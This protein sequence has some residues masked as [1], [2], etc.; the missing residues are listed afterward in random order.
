VERGSKKRR[1]KKEG[2]ISDLMGKS[3]KPVIR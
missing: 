2:K 3:T 1:K